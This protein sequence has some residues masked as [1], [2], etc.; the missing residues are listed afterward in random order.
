MTN[1]EST[2]T[3]NRIRI[4]IGKTVTR[5]KNPKSI[6]QNGK[7]GRRRLSVKAK[8]DNK[9]GKKKELLIRGVK[10]TQ[11]QCLLNKNAKMHISLRIFNQFKCHTT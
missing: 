2:Y 8:D 3:K 1:C 9:V 6:F 5:A 4:R 11:L 10:Y 7:R